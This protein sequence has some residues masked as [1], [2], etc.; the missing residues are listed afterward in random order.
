MPEGQGCRCIAEGR[1][2]SSLFWRLPGVGLGNFPERPQSGSTANREEVGIA[3]RKSL[4][5]PECWGGDEK[6]E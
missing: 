5:S 1:I 6:L 3:G 4:R 2:G